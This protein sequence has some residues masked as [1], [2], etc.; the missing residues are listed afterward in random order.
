MPCSRPPSIR[1]HCATRCQGKHRLISSQLDAGIRDKR[2]TIKDPFGPVCPPLSLSLFSSLS[3][4][5]SNC[6]FF[7][8]SPSLLSFFR[9]SS[10]N[11]V[12]FHKLQECFGYITIV[13]GIYIKDIYTYIICLYISI[14]IYIYRHIY[15]FNLSVY[16][17]I[18]S[19]YLIFM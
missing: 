10:K 18:Y 4:P 16:Q 12:N 5:F 9:K 13:E 7:Y 8:I 19:I 15:I 11:F 17:Y 6:P 14:Y 3:V 2:L 1:R